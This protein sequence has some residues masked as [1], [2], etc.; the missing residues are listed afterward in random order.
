MHRWRGLTVES[1]GTGISRPLSENVNLLGGMLGEAIRER[2]GPETLELVEELRLLCKEAEEEGDATKRDRAADR[3]ASLGLEDLVALLRAF[4]AFFHL[5]NQAEKH[6]IVRINRARAREGGSEAARPESIG[7]VVEELAE[8]GASFD[9]V[10]ELFGRLDIQPTLTAHPTEARRRT[11]LEKQR[12]IAELLARLRRGD[13]T[14]EEE[15]ALLDAIYNEIVILLSTDEIRPERPSVRDE[16]R[17]GL[18]FLSGVIW[19]AVPRIHRDVRRALLRHY[20]AEPTLPAFVRYRSW[21]GSDRDGNPNVTAEVTRWTFGVQRRA[22]IEGHVREM[23]A[24]RDE[25]SLSGR[26]APVPRELEAS[27]ARA[28]DEAPKHH[29]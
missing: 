6:E 20:D 3:V 2:Y 23:E 11:V 18:H 8:A 7:A 21:I 17:Q 22:A 25:L 14:P 27:L 10:L 24:L 4:T 26:H 5:V 15:E 16:V 13:P 1:E 28:E 12:R 9:A 29:R 19:D